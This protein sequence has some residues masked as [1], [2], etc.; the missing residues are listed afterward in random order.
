MPPHFAQVESWMRPRILACL[1]KNQR[2]WV[3]LRAQ[4]G[5]VDP[6]HA[7]L[8]YLYKTFAPGSPGEKDIL[9]RRGL[10]PNVCTN[11]AP[12]QIELM[13]WRA[14]VRRLHSLG[15]LP[16]DIM[17]SYRALES[18]FGAVFD[19]A[20]PQLHMRWIQMKNRLGLPHLVTP[21]AFREVSEFADAELSALV[22]LGGSSFNP[23]LPLTDN[24]KARQQQIKDGERQ[25][26]AK[27][28]AAMKAATA[29]AA[30]SALSTSVEQG[31]QPTAARLSSPLSPWAQHC[32]FWQK[33]ECKRGV[34]CHF[35]HAGFPVEEKR[36]FIC[37][38][39]EHSSKDCTCPGG[40]ADPEKDKH[41]SEY[42][43]RRKQ[44]E[45]AGKIGK[46]SK[47]K[48]GGKKG[49]NGKTK[50][51]QGKEHTGKGPTAS[52]CVDLARAAAAS[53][54]HRVFPRDCVALDS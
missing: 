25:R 7:L 51:N 41:W 19:K 12:A 40:G 2:E 26:A 17:M 53:G 50:G 33:G 10:N 49:G 1:P 47:G 34:S 4:T 42:R 24:Q 35:H 14:D 8:Y 13:R 16:P 3:D 23:G 18:I 31:S 39:T 45:E 32:T 11:T 21:A 36:C 22:L 37:K 54:V 5:V 30:T 9:L 29:A 52:A 48:G 28:A 6:S 27:A 20:E 44:A 43:V 38:S 15:C 46:G